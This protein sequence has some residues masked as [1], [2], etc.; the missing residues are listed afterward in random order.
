ME[1][2]V[3]LFKKFMQFPKGNIAELRQLIAESIRWNVHVTLTVQ[4]SEHDHKFATLL[5]NFMF[6]E[7]PHIRDNND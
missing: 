4:Y 2:K 7:N 5:N 6:E 1:E 3:K